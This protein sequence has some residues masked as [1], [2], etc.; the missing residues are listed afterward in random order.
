M[1]VKTKAIGMTKVLKVVNLTKRREDKERKRKKILEEKKE[2][3][4]DLNKKLN[5]FY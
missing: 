1:R 2:I 3:L 4:R 5:L